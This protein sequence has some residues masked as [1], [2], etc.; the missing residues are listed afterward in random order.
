MLFKSSISGKTLGLLNQL[1]QLESL[2]DF[3][4][5]GRTALSLQIG[6]RISFDIDLFGQGELGIQIIKE[7]ENVADEV[8]QLSRS[9]V[10]MTLMVNGIKVDLV[11]Y[12]F[13]LIEP[14]LVNEGIRMIGLKDICAMKLEA[15]N[16]RGKKRDFTDLYFLLNQFT[17]KDMFSFY[18]KKYKSGNELMLLRSLMY[19]EDANR[20]E[21]VKYIGNPVAWEDIKKKVKEQAQLFMDG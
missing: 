8:E 16:N 10:I 4:L 17:L 14:S 20:D 3:H 13:D 11:K 7:I 5:V 6:H 12:P 2:H 19:F 15:I 21:P 9:N 1:M 18:Q